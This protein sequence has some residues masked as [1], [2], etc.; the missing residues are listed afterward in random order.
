MDAGVLS[1]IRPSRTQRASIIQNHDPVHMPNPEPN[2]NGQRRELQPAEPAQIPPLPLPCPYSGNGITG[3]EFV[4]EYQV[5]DHYVRILRD[6]R[7][8]RSKEPIQSHHRKT[9]F[10]LQQNALHLIETHGE[11]RIG[12]LT[13]TCRA[14]TTPFQTRKFFSKFW[15][16]QLR[17]LFE[18]AISVVDVKEGRPHIHAIVFCPHD[19][20]S[21]FNKDA[22][23][24]MREISKKR[25]PS[26][27][28]RQRLGDLGRNLTTNVRL[29]TIWSRLRKTVSRAG[30]ARRVELTPLLETPEC[31]VG[32]LENAYRRGVEA[33]RRPR[34]S[35]SRPNR[36]RVRMVCY[37]TELER[38]CRLPFGYTD[39]RD[40][41]RQVAAVAKAL[42]VTETEKTF[43]LLYGPKWAYH[44]QSVLEELTTYHGRSEPENWP[45]QAI[46]STV[47]KYMAL[48]IEGAFALQSARENN[49][50]TG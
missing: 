50:A 41:R 48:T 40:W 19:I 46:R 3:A 12:F 44:L 2:P 49:I 35:S 16:Q 25:P 1:A 15:K 42:G 8:A 28:E 31:L 17:H 11:Q 30:F 29:K 14:R 7:K 18:H 22:Y 43:K 33:T 34:H 47:S 27:P 21:G 36:S 10:A 6:E 24:E 5:Q 23:Y 37:S 38:I 26:P 32:Y 13:L 39:S 9:A 4:D 20:A 45:H